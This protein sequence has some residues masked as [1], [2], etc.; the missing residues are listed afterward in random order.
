[1]LGLVLVAF[2]LYN[3]IRP[4]LPTPGSEKLSY[5]FGFVAGILGGAYNTNGPPAV[6]YGAL[7]DWSPESYR[8][9]LQEYFISDG[10]HMTIGGRDLEPQDRRRRWG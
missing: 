3:I 10:N 9:T 2:G 8:A 5:V 1:M 4:K 6:I 7:R